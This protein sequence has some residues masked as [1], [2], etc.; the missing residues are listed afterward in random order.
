[1]YGSTLSRHNLNVGRDRHLDPVST[2]RGWV[3]IRHRLT[4]VD[5][6]TPREMVEASIQRYHV[7]C[8]PPEPR[9]ERGIYNLF[10]FW[11]C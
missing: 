11:A 9:R 10:L 3:R 5:D 1:M 7:A 8:Q 2:T 4:I 6:S